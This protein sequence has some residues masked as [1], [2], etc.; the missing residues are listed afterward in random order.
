[1]PKLKNLVARLSRKVPSEAKHTT[2]YGT[3]E[4]T[5]FMCK[6]CKQKGYVGEAYLE[7]S[8]KRKHPD[9]IRPY[10]ATCWNETN[11]K[12]RK[13]EDREISN[14]LMSFFK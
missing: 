5:T 10:H 6:V 11:G 14:T 1:M 12:T 2:I 8:A 13:E 7:S 9:Q 4:Y 3:Q